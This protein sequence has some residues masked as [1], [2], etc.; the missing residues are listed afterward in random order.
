MHA[1]ALACGNRKWISQLTEFARHGE[2]E[3]HQ[4]PAQP[5]KDALKPVLDELAERR[6]VVIGEDADLAAV[7]LRLLR[8]E[9]LDDVV[10]GFV[11]A[12]RHSEVAATWGLPV[13]M[14]RALDV[15]LH[16]EPD[17][18][19]LVRDDN[20][21]VLVGMG[22]LG[23]VRG[24]AYCDDEQVL[25]GFASRIEVRPDPDQGLAVRVI[26]RGL[27]GKRTRRVTGRAFQIGC[28]PT[29]PL[30]DG[31]RHPRTIGRW[32]WYR[33]TSDLRLV[34]GLS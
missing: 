4:V 30:H 13:D 22:V 2:W 16:A 32:I 8:T 19:P 11:P 10:L 29:R 34:R 15:A 21:G 14:E 18:V 24:V 17:P 3:L 31:V 26:R 6:L 12:S 1:L 20:G 27:L 9:R 33:H 7:A 28:I 23:P 5:D 25:R